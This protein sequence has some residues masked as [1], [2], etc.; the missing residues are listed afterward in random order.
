MQFLSQAID[1][2]KKVGKLIDG[3]NDYDGTREEY[4][5][6]ACD[7]L[8]KMESVRD[9]YY[10]IVFSLSSLDALTIDENLSVQ[11]RNNI[12][13]LARK[14]KDIFDEQKQPLDELK[15]NVM[16]EILMGLNND[17]PSA[18]DAISSIVEMT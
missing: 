11:E 16:T 10:D 9:A 12:K 6:K 13:E 2:V 14:V 5:A 7:L 17:N 3:L 18:A 8:Q 15:E 4:I 1:Y